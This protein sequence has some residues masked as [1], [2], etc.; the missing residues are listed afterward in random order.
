[1][2]GRATQSHRFF[3]F[4]SA[5]AVFLIVSCATPNYG[6]RAS[7]EPQA[8]ELQSV[9]PRDAFLFV[10][11]VA[12]SPRCVNCH[13]RGDRP[14]QLDF[15]D[16]HFHTMYIHRQFTAL[17]G[18]CITCHQDHNLD[19]PHAPPG[20]GNAVQ[21][22]WRMPS[23]L[24]SYDISTTAEELCHI[25]TG[26]TNQ[27]EEGPNQ[28]RSRSPAELLDHVTN[29]PLVNWGFAPGPGRIPALPPGVGKRSARKYIA[30]RRPEWLKEG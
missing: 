27:F 13:A 28:G 14:I 11:K 12:T 9:T 29:D 8:V 15:A 5:A 26:P 3:F 17:G 20:A 16:A 21:G 19:M 1:M 6:P 7:R 18:L 30:K 4:F 22:H 23:P 2:A 10:H 25:W 24:K